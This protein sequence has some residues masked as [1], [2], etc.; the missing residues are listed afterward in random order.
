QRLLRDL[1]STATRIRI[2]LDTIK[3]I[4]QKLKPTE[5]AFS[6][7][8]HNDGSAYTQVMRFPEALFEACKNN[9]NSTLSSLLDDEKLLSFSS[10]YEDSLFHR[11]DYQNLSYFF[12]G[13]LLVDARTTKYLNRPNDQP[14]Y[15]ALSS[16]SLYP[17]NCLAIHAD[18][19]SS[20][21]L[22]KLTDEAKR[23]GISIIDCC[24]FNDRSSDWHTDRLITRKTNRH[25]ALAGNQAACFLYLDIP[26]SIENLTV[27]HVLRLDQKGNTIDSK[28]VHLPAKEIKIS[29]APTTPLCEDYGSTF[30]S[31]VFDVSGEVDPRTGLFHAHYPIANLS[32][33]NGQGPEIDLTL[34]YSALRGNEAG[35]GDGWAF[36]FSSLEIRDRRLTL[37]TGQ[38]CELTDQEWAGLSKGKTL[39]KPGYWLSSNADYST[40]T[41][42][43]LNGKR[44]VLTAPQGDEMEPNDTFRKKLIILL[45]A[46]HAGTAPDANLLKLYQDANTGETIL[47][48]LLPELYKVAG[49]VDWNASVTEWKKDKA[50]LLKKISYWERP[51]GQLLPSEVTSPQGGTL[52]IEW[53]RNQGQFLLK[54]I[55]SDGNVILSSTY[56]APSSGM[57]T[58]E[59]SVWP[60]TNEAYTVRLELSSYAL[61]D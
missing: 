8:D 15:S 21:Q 9:E 3:Y 11:S 57:S 26:Q 31:E 45:K 7:L 29:S 56:S 61:T 4:E 19:T 17:N 37:A 49:I 1:T 25:E 42:D 20:T 14:E 48:G 33:L 53:S 39:S 30:R 40:F 43:H 60:K 36:R 52:S 24:Y 23:N 54:K 22:I 13:P 47:A 59:I 5:W 6:L 32:G 34:H 58:V 35:L 12:H 38:T 55:S 51:F 16:L 10:G 18:K 27:A 44:E 28:A 50:G 46:A 2:D 41:L